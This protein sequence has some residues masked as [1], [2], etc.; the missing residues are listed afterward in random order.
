MGREMQRA[1]GQEQQVVM[2]MP[3]LVGLDGVQKMSKSYN[4][5]IGINDEPS[6]M[7]DK[8]M[9]IS[10]DLM[11]LYYDL[12]SS[13]SLE[14]ISQM[15]QDVISGKLHPMESKKALAFEL[16]ERYHDRTFAVDASKHFA[17]VHSKKEIPDNMPE[18]AVSFEKSW[19]CAVM[20]EVGLVKGTSEA[21]RLIQ[22]GA[23][24]INE[25]KLSDE[26]LNL[27][28]GSFIIQTGKRRFAKVEIK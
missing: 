19:I 1:Y 5:Y 13:R 22:Q 28:K 24:K 18:Y 4:N 27:S 9:S 2:T 25:E 17:T 6:D 20:K 7:Y 26:N 14:E 10:D 23:V 16:V 11:W 8:A 21:R 15:K 3:L 12:I